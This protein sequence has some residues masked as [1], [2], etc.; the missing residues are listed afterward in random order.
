[1]Y[2]LFLAT[3]AIIRLLSVGQYLFH[4]HSGYAVAKRLG[5]GQAAVC[6]SI[7]REKTVDDCNWLCDRA[8]T[9][10]V[11]AYINIMVIDSSYPSQVPIS[12]LPRHQEL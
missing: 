12:A 6:H 7:E 11:W 3:L 10:T 8:P 4:L 9:Y 2:R 5:Q 1:M